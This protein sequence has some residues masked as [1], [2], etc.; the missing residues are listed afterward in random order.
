M[1]I[2]NTVLIGCTMPEW[3]KR[4][5]GHYLQYISLLFS[6]MRLWSLF[7]F[8]NVPH[9]CGALHSLH[10]ADTKP[11]VN[12]HPTPTPTAHATTQHI[13]TA[14]KRERADCVLRHLGGPARHVARGTAAS[15]CI[16][17]SPCLLICS[18]YLNHQ[19]S[20]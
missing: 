15:V 2:P 5:D 3:R 17:Q 4:E 9:L 11:C 12:N 8:V 18:C 20:I 10:G 19:S 13:A 6:C 1:G 14:T 7:P 16:L